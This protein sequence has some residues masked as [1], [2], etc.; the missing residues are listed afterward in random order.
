ML[1]LNIDGVDEFTSEFKVFGIIEIRLCLA[2]SYFISCKAMVFRLY[3]AFRNSIFQKNFDFIFRT[4]DDYV[5]G[6][7]HKHHLSTTTHAVETERDLF[8]PPYTFVKGN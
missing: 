2:I 4:K 1:K 5:P 7:S 3:L 6:C 8:V